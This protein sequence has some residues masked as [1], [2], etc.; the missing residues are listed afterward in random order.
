MD[1]VKGTGRRRPAPRRAGPPTLNTL[2]RFRD[3]EANAIVSKGI[4]V[5]LC[6]AHS[7]LPFVA[8]K[9]SQAPVPLTPDKR[10][11]AEVT[12][13]RPQL[14][15]QAPMSSLD[16]LWERTQHARKFFEKKEICKVFL[17]NILRKQK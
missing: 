13:Q 8:Q 16:P 6:V 10:A 17:V 2:V 5:V 14:T 15:G 12:P 9:N 7:S 1:P 4:Q 3:A 11:I